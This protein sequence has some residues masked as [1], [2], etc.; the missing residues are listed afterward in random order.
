MKKYVN[1]QYI[2]LTPEEI[3]SIQEEAKR[4]EEVAKN[5]PPTIEER[6]AAMESALIALMGGI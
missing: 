2:E 6:L 5:L 1:G 4:A 3:A